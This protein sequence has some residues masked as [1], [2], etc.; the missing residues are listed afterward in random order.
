MPP[1][2]P[3]NE[4]PVR[5]TTP[6]IFVAKLEKSL[7]SSRLVATSV[8]S[9]DFAPL[10][11]TRART[12]A[13][14]F[15]LYRVIRGFAHAGVERHKSRHTSTQRAILVKPIFLVSLRQCTQSQIR[16]LDQP[17]DD[18]DLGLR[19]R[20]DRRVSPEAHRAWR[21]HPGA[22]AVPRPYPNANRTADL[23]SARSH[24]AAPFSGA[25][26]E[27]PSTTSGGP[28]KRGDDE[29]GCARSDAARGT[30]RRGR[31]GAARR[32]AGAA[33]PRRSSAAAGRGARRKRTPSSGLRDMEG[34]SRGPALNG[35]RDDNIGM[36][37]LQKQK[38]STRSL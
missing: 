36:L 19:R 21:C 26:D 31:G 28:A 6:S 1:V 38:A 24:G 17:N 9:V 34:V 27:L 8:V 22:D 25:R 15:L 20:R 30:R 4:G 7:M 5:R 16:C 18:G 32:V 12:A 13:K 14:A 11:V 2:I 23:A 29:A 3:S 35:G 33:P 37:R 10:L